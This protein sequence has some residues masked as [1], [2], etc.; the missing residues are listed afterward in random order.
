MKRSYGI[1]LSVIG[2]SV[3]AAAQFRRGGEAQAAFADIP[4]CRGA[5]YSVDHC[6][7]AYDNALRVH[8]SRTRAFASRTECQ[9][10]TDT[11]CVPLATP[12]RP[13]APEQFGPAMSA[14]MLNPGGCDARTD[15]S[16]EGS[17]GGGSGGGGGAVGGG[18]SGQR[19]PAGEPLYEAR[20]QPG[21]YRDATAFRGGSPGAPTIKSSTI[22]RGGFGGFR[23]FSG[24]G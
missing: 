16:C 10:A 23:G 1:I 7:T 14:F 9:T 12:G 6:R 22:S 21:S 24:R 17:S 2:F 15:R 20:S 8:R 19:K 4:Q 5:G 11:T 13:D 3:F 18:G